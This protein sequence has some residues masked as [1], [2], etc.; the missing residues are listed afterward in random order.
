LA[1]RKYADLNGEGARLYGGRYNPRGVP[2]VY[3]AESISLASLEVL[4]HLDKSEIPG[5]YVALRI[6]VGRGQVQSLSMEAAQRVEVLSSGQ[7]SAVESFLR[8]FYAR[9]VLRVP[10]AIIP[11]EHNYILLPAAANFSARVLWVESFRFDP[12]L[13]SLS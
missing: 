13:F 2:A 10:S 6:E 7:S 5:D 11:R 8:E 4:V 3:A 12:R 9:P 1:R